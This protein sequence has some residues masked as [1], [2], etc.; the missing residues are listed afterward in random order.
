[1]SD[2]C[3]DMSDLQI[4]QGL[5]LCLATWYW[6]Y[7]ATR[8]ILDFFLIF[9]WGDAKLSSFF[10]TKQSNGSH[11]ESI[12][13]QNKAIV[14]TLKAKLWIFSRN[15]C[16]VLFSKKMTRCFSIIPFISFFFFADQ[17][18]I[19]LFIYFVLMIFIRSYNLILQS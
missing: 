7:E 14:P 12:S 9:F 16:F 3:W 1:M 6:D 13:K 18:S 11:L 8:K 15:H 4:K 2:E 17:Y 10:K 5:S 19:Y